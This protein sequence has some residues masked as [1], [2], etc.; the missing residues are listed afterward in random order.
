MIGYSWVN[1][2]FWSV[3]P[4]IGWTR[5]GYEP[6]GTSCTVV[7]YPNEGYTS[8][9]IGCF[10]ACYLV[11]IV[12]LCYCKLRYRIVDSTKKTKTVPLSVSTLFFF[13]L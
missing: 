13:V 8:Y 3:T 4:L 9:M 11:P 6:S 1:S 12:A 5:F 7:Y 2:L 10:T